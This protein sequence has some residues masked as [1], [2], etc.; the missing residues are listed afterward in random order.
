MI[1]GSLSRRAAL[2]WFKAV[3]SGLQMV[4][5]EILVDFDF[6]CK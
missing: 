6:I 3:D 5:R 2:H 1:V 4:E